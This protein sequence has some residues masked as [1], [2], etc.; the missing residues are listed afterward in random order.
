[1]ESQEEP[2]RRLV[3]QSNTSVLKI[4]ALIDDL[5]NASK[6]YEHRIQLKKSHFDLGRLIEDCCYPL[7]LS[8]QLV[9]RFSRM[10]KIRS[11]QMQKESSGS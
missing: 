9:V 2:V 6:A 11:L 4:T 10:K 5:L 1:M 8:G 3:G 7:E